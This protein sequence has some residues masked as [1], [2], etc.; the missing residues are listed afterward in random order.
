L[1]F[2][3]NAG[4]ESPKHTVTSRGEK[5]VGYFKN[6]CRPLIG[7]ISHWQ[8]IHGDYND[9]ANK[10]ATWFIDPPYQVGGQRYKENKIDFTAL[11]EWCRSRTGQV[12]VCENEGGK[13]LPFEPLT[14]MRGC[15]KST[16]E[17]MWYKCST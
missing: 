17:H 15:R 2:N 10:K 3:I 5:C 13:W 6:R 14:T 12:I 8:I 9:I 7:N 11:G 1:S 4:V 16:T